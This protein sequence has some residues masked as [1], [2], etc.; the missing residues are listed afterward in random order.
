MTAQGTTAVVLL[1]D[2]IQADHL[3]RETA[4]GGTGIG[5]GIRKKME[6][7]V[8][9]VIEV[10]VDR[11]GVGVGGTGRDPMIR[12]R[13]KVREL[14]IGRGMTMMSKERCVLFLRI[15]RAT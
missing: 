12:R 11:I 13:G 7:T 2:Q 3:D 1:T 4:D 14:R 15:R 6:G 10:T 8:V 9:M 5:S